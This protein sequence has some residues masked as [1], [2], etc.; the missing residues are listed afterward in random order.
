MRPLGGKFLTGRNDGSD[1]FLSGL[2]AINRPDKKCK[3]AMKDAPIR[4]EP[5]RGVLY[6]QTEPD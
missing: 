4:S 2:P 1:T 5:R 6:K 3:N